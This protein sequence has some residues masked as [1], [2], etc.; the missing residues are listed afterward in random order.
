MKLYFFSPYDVLRARTNTISDVRLCEGF[1]ANGCEVELIAPFVYRKDNLRRE[2]IPRAYCLADPYR[3]TILPTPFGESTPKW[4]FLPVM[5]LLTL[6]AFL[7]ILL[8]N[9]GR[10]QDVVIMSRSVDLLLPALC[11]SALLGRSRPRIV[12]WAHEVI[13]KP[14]YLWVYRKAD[15]VVGTNSAIT[16]DMHWKVGIPEDRLGI[17]L[18]PITEAQ[19]HTRV[20]REQARH[21]LGIET[22]RPLIVYTG[23]LYAG[24]K[25]IEY[26]LDAASRLPGYDF[27]VTGGKPEAVSHYERQCAGR[28]MNNVRF[29]GFLRHYKDVGYY[30]FAADVVVSY[31]SRFD[32]LVEYNLPNKIC[33]YMLSGNPIV[34]S[35]FRAMHDVLNDTNAIFVAAEDPAALAEGIRHAITDPANARRKADQAL[36]DVGNMTFRKRTAALLR[37]FTSLR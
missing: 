10:Q 17:S 16:G 28:G 31:Y 35:R 3:V 30:Q 9:L 33:E 2:E 8:T 6:G 18:N 27:I 13:F 32:H 5:W 37:L 34:T 19:L 12:A 7:R 11:T 29:T 1:A 25:E 14:R 26:L 22:S 21:K 4:F 20:S 24:Q 15:A 36:E 23:K